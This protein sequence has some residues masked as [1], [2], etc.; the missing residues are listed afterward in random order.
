MTSLIHKTLRRMVSTWR[1][2][3]L[4]AKKL[5][6]KAAEV[7]ELYRAQNQNGQE[8]VLKWFMGKVFRAKVHSAKDKDEW[9][10]R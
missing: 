3:T 8:E 1:P 6:Q 4:S 10:P 5:E 9:R 7:I 2:N